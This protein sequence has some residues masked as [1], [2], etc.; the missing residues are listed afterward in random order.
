MTPDPIDAAGAAVTPLPA[1]PPPAGRLPRHVAIIMDGN[2]RW[3]ERRGKPR[4]DG[5]RIGARAVRATVEHCLA[6]GIPHLTLFAFSSENWSRPAS[7]VNALMTLFLKALDREVDQLD[8][9]GVRLDFIGDLTPFSDALRVRMRRAVERTAGNR[10]IRVNVAVNYGGRWDIANACRRIAERVARGEIEPAAVDVATIASE[11]ALADQPE[12]DLLIRSGGD[13]RISNFLLW[14][15]AYTELVFTD[16][17]WPDFDAADL[18][19]AFADYAA[20][21]RRF[22]MTGAQVRDRAEAGR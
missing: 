21:E 22:G 19:R 20:R 18:E 10:A 7:E 13:Q 15:L 4:T 9:H 1:L 8:R 17:L 12:P 2:G 11:L 14:Q 5:H 3:A 16:T 6:R